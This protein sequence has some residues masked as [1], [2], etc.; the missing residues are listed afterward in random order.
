MTDKAN[1]GDSSA[2][3]ELHLQTI[4]EGF[5]TRLGKSFLQSLYSFL[6]QEELVFVFR[7]DHKTVGFVSCSMHS[8][9]MMK[10]FLISCPASLVKLGWM[11]IKNPKIL[12]PLFETF[13][14]PSRSHTNSG[15]QSELKLPSTELLSICVDPVFQ[16]EYIGTQLLHA[17]EQHLCLLGINKYKVIAGESLVGANKFYLKNGFEFATKINIHGDVLS[18]IYTK[19]L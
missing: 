14:A 11:L 17:L 13:R 15:S 12:L 19:E 5:L 4:T 2:L 18:N 6:I 10:K 7:N 16:K 8:D 3:A 9:G 1:S